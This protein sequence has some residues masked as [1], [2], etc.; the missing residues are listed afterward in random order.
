MAGSQHGYVNE[1]CNAEVENLTVLPAET[2]WEVDKSPHATLT[3]PV[4]DDEVICTAWIVSH[5]VDAAVVNTISAL[6]ADTDGS[7]A[8]ASTQPSVVFATVTGS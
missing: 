8:V 4:S 7:A 6:F 1:I 2:V 5:P 3:P